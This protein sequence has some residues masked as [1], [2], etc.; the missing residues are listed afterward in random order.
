MEMSEVWKKLSSSPDGLSEEDY[1]KK[2]LKYGLNELKKVKTTTLLGLFIEQFNDFLVIILLFSVA[3]SALLGEWIDAIAILFIVIMNAIL[4]F[5]Q[6]FRAEKAIEALE[7]MTAPHALVYRNGILQKVP[8]KELVPGDVIELASGDSIPADARIFWCFSCRLNEASLTGESLPVEKYA[9]EALPID[10]PLADRKNMVFQGTTTVYGRAK[11]VIADTG[12]N[13]EMGRIATMIAETRSTETPLTTQLNEFG[14]KVGIGILLICFIVFLVGSYVGLNAVDFNW[15]EFPNIAVTMFIVGVSLAVAAIPEGL[16]A[17]VTLALAIGVQRMAK[18]RAVVRKLK[19]VET[20]GS[21]TVICSD[22]TGTLTTNEMTVKRILLPQ[23]SL[24]V[25]G[26]GYKPVGDILENETV[27]QTKDDPALELLIRIGI[28]NNSAHLVEKNGNYSIIGD[29]TEGALIVLGEKVELKPEWIKIYEIP[30]DSDRKMMTVIC[31]REDGSKIACFKGAPDILLSRSIHIL[32]GKTSKSLTEEDKRSL[33][34]NSEELAKKAFRMIALGYREVDNEILK[35]VKGV[36]DPTKILE[37]NI[38]YVGEVGLLDPPRP[39][40]AESVAICRKAGIKTVMITGDH[41]VTAEA[42]AQEVGII[43]EGENAGILTGRDLDQMSDEELNDSVMETGIYARVSPKHKMRIV[44]ALQENNQVVAMTGDGVNDAP[45]LKKADIGVAMGIMGTD[46]AREAA[47]MILTDDNFATITAA[48]EEGRGIYDNM[49]KFIGYLLGCNAG[50]V[51]TVFFGILLIAFLSGG[52]AASSAN[53]H[54][55][56]IIPLLAVQILYMNLVT[57]GLPALALGVDPPEPN[58]MDRKPRDPGEGFLSRNMYANILLAGIVIAAG[59]LWLFFWELGWDDHTLWQD[60]LP[61]AQTIAF[62]VIIMFQK[63]MALSS[64]SETESSFTMK[65]QNL[66]LWG[67][68]FL[69]IFLQFVV[70]YVPVFQEILHTV[71][72]TVMDWIVIFTV[73]STVLFAEE[74]RKCV[75]RRYVAEYA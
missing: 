20:L 12:L 26:E 14:K 75:F 39:E 65:E 22:K 59:T 29:P 19:A 11:A 73:A 27:V 36:K 67:A 32:E 74:I 49:K 6:E 38:T 3:I 15:D 64:R 46:V 69:T 53:G 35:A 50:E 28:L 5:V 8:A 66:W 40:S 54:A 51:M 31:K 61:R 1:N 45:A 25:S 24:M 21:T 41:Q 4:G 18:R 23:R 37:T 62:C 7:A 2:V 56:T 9:T 55:E 43:T 48:V 17:V 47:A 60:R 30:F 34:A 52:E 44:T 70:V 57:D 71:S 42:I 68:I 63:F 33:S 58:L 72:L 16:P 10:T 13:T